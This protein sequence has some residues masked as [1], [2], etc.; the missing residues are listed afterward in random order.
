[1]IL[2]CGKEDGL[3]A[4]DD[5]GV[6]V[7]RGEAAIRGADSPTVREKLGP[8]AAR[9]NNRFNRNHQA[10][11][12]ELASQRIRIVWNGRRLVDRTPDTVAA[13]FANDVESSAARFAFNC[14]ADFVHPVAH[15]GHA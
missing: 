1:M 4:S 12:E 7:V 15:A 9:R 14:P 8:A 5:D 2:Y 11:G 13:E 6:L 10:F 3:A